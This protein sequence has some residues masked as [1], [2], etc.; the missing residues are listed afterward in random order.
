M[1]EPSALASHLTGG[2]EGPPGGSPPPPLGSVFLA[3]LS[4]LLEPLYIV[5]VVLDCHAV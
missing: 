5:G 3:G 2:L 4:L 1:F